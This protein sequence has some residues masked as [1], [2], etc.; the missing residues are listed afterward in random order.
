MSETNHAMKQQY[1]IYYN[2]VP[3]VGSGS[4]LLV[5]LFTSPAI[6]KKVS[7]VLGIV[8]SFH[9]FHPWCI[10]ISRHRRRPHPDECQPVWLPR[11]S[12]RVPI[13]VSICLNMSLYIVY[14]ELYIYSSVYIYSYTYVYIRFKK[15]CTMMINMLQ[16]AS[17]GAA[18]TKC[19]RATWQMLAISRRRLGTW[20]TI[21]LSFRTPQSRPT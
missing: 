12:N 14:I 17:H 10:G 9:I 18:A 2:I 1:I 15:K 7:L 6:R 19:C 4:R 21:S 8:P 11:C 20:P 16:M 13:F 5:H 3:G